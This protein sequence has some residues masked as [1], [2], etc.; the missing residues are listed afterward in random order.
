MI[1]KADWSPEV[2]LMF[3][4]ASNHVDDKPT[5]RKSDMLFRLGE[6]QRRA[7][8][9][10]TDNTGIGNFLFADN[11]ETDTLERS[12]ISAEATSGAMTCNW[13]RNLGSA[14]AARFST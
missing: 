7:D 5:F 6:I 11:P 2:G 4:D 10:D 8:V 14:I 3:T 13:H 12:H 1:C 9:R